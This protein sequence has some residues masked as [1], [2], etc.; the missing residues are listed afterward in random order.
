MPQLAPKPPASSESRFVFPGKPYKGKTQKHEF[1]GLEFKTIDELLD[2]PDEDID[3]VVGGLLPVAG[4]S[5]LVGAPKAGKSTLARNLAM[6]VVRGLT[7]LGRNT[8]AGGVL[9]L[10]LEEKPAEVKRHFTQL[11]MKHGCPL[12]I[13][14]G[15]MPREHPLE[16]LA[17]TIAKVKPALVILDPIFKVVRVA[18]GNDYV[19]VT[20]G[21]EPL[22]NLARVTRSHI[23]GV[24]HARKGGGSQGEDALGST[25][26]V[27]AVDCYLSL[28]RDAA[29]R[30]INSMGRYG[31]DLPETVL[32]MDDDGCIGA[33]GTR[34]EID[35]KD[36]GGE[37]LAYLSDLSEPVKQDDIVGKVTGTGKIVRAALGDLVDRGQIQR[38]GAGKKGNPFLYSALSP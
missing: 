36:T 7:W 15:P 34:A 38:T 2:E 5:L 8:Q 35:R 20:E 29:R 24:H 23:L 37:I 21:M 13:V 14:F 4:L 10:A 27:G 9:Y 11:G 30:T 6:C 32:V 22:L 33:A 17:V 28:K 12:F 26:L 3:Y 25:A 1:S 31:E 16:E 19:Q 18:D